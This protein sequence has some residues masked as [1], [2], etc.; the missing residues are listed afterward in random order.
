MKILLIIISALFLFPNAVYAQDYGDLETLCRLYSHHTPDADVK[1]QDGFDV[2]GND[3]VSANVSD[4]RIQTP[5]VF[6]IPLYVKQLEALN[7]PVDSILTPELSVG[8]VV[9]DLNS[10]RITFN[11]DPIDRSDLEVL[12]LDGDYEEIIHEESE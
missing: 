12:C 10:D 8:E 2:R 6:H 4:N 11:G 1:Y 3:V 5:K 9:V 7:L